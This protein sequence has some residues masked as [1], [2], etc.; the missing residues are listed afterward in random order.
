MRTYNDVRSV[1]LD[2]GM[3]IMGI[4]HARGELSRAKDAVMNALK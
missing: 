4:G 2:G 1:L 3:T